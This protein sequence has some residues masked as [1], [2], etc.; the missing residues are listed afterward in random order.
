MWLI[1]AGAFVSAV[2]HRDD[3]SLLVVRSRDR[4]SLVHLVREIGADE[5]TVVSQLPADYP[6][7]TTLPKAAVARWAHDQVAAIT[8]PNFK[9]HAARVRDSTYSSFLHDVWSCGHELTDLAT[10]EEN[11]RAW[12]QRDREWG[13]YPSASD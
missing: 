13:R 6:Y 2:E 12:A 4:E 9:S 5:S 8:Y 11:D 7:R 10:V 3:P 1:T